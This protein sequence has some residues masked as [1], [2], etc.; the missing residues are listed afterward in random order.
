MEG[1]KP[2]SLNSSNFFTKFAKHDTILVAGIISHFN[3]M[4]NN[5]YILQPASSEIEIDSLICDNNNNIVCLD[6]SVNNLPLQ[7]MAN[8]NANL[9]ADFQSYRNSATTIKKI[10]D[11]K[12]EFENNNQV[13]RNQLEEVIYYYYYLFE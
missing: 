5:D 13:L 12:D 1:N 7:E 4:P 10:Q 2:G 9:A 6:P 3:L 11:N 8:N